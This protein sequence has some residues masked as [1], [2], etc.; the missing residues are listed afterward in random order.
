MVWGGGGRMVNF[1][2]IMGVLSIITLLVIED[3]EVLTCGGDI[4][5]N[6][7]HLITGSVSTRLLES[8]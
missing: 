7:P 8:V 1:S 4:V 3:G 6:T 5:N 2:L